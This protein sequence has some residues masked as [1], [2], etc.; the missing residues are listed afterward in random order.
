MTKNTSPPPPSA[1]PDP[2][3]LA[4]WHITTMGCLYASVIF[5]VLTLLALPFDLSLSAWIKQ[6]RIRGDLERVIMLAEVF[7]YG[8][9]VLFVMITAAQI[10]QRGWRV[11]PRLFLVFACVGIVAN[12]C[13]VLFVARWRPNSSFEPEGIRDTF[14]QWLPWL[15]RDHL[16]APWGRDLMSFPSGHTATATGLALSLSIL[17]PRGT[18]WFCVLAFFAAFQRIETR[19]HYLSDTLAGASVACLVM[20]LLLHSRWV[21]SRLR[22]IESSGVLPAVETQAPSSAGQGL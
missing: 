18:I 1:A 6:N 20:A 4:P 2:D 8:W 15:D 13:K 5:I 22:R 11:V 7:G 16:P 17:Y 19:A 21:E 14:A 10:D 9:T 12:I 3:A